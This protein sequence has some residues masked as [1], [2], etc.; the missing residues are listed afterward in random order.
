VSLNTWHWVSLVKVSSIHW[1]ARVYDGNGN[2]NDVALISSNST[3]IY[4]AEVTMEAAFPGTTTPQWSA[5]FEAYHP[6]Y[7]QSGVYKDW[8]VSGA[9][10]K[11]YLKTGVVGV[12]NNFCPGTY[13]TRPHYFSDSR[14]WYAGSGTNSTGQC[15]WL[16]FPSFVSSQPDT[17]ST[18]PWSTEMV[19]RNNSTATAS[20]DRTSFSS[21]GSVLCQTYNT[22]APLSQGYVSSCANAT[23][24]IIGSNVDIS[25]VSESRNGT[26]TA[27]ARNGFLESD[28]NNLEWGQLSNRFHLPVIMSNYYSWDSRI[29]L[30][31]PGT[32]TTSVTIT[33]RKPDGTI[34]NGTTDTFSLAP[35]QT[36]IRNIVGGQQDV[37]YSAQVDSGIPIAV[38]VR[39]YQGNV[40]TPYN[41]IGSTSLTNYQPLIMNDYYGWVT[42]IN[43]INPNSTAAQIRIKYYNSVGGVVFDT[44]TRTVPAN[45][46]VSYYSPTEGLPSGPSDG[47]MSAVLT[48]LNQQQVGVVVNQSC[49]FGSAITKGKNYN[50]FV[51]GR[52]TV[53]LPEV[54]NHVGSEHWVSSIN[55]QNTEVFPVN[56][57]FTYNGT[58][59]TY[60]NLPG[61]SLKSIYIPALEGTAVIRESVVITT[62]YGNVVVVVNHSSVTYPNSSM[63][64]SFN[65]IDR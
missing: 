51:L 2:A 55:I 59:H 54:L 23:S 6:Q 32:A 21:G 58:P 64:R 30:F 22:I 40:Y 52:G 8:E 11:N 63:E 28:S 12:P 61:Y 49:C 16:F 34:P 65:G 7:Y 9:A 25:V 19:V 14:W 31:N 57:H 29:V 62:D 35:N 15:D 20:V 47:I 24:S 60:N 39:Q 43:I 5:D 45:A 48:S 13:A 27:F 41:G 26:S 50:G 37:L 4:N 17:P 10:A 38:S 56:V 33:Y 53:I 36:L 3:R 44:G 46:S 42:S 1:V 18:S